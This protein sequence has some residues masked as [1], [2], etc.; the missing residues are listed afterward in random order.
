LIIG[1]FLAIFQQI[2]GINTIM[3][4]A[5]VIFDTLGFSM[6]SS[7]FQTV[8]IGCINFIFT[9]VAMFFVDKLGRKPLL[10]IGSTLMSLSLGILA[11]SVNKGI[12]GYWVLVCILVYIAAFAVSLGPVT[13]VLIS[14]IFPNKYRG[15]GMSISTMFLWASCFAIALLFP[16]VLSSLGI[17]NTFLLF[18]V[19]CIASFVFYWLCIKETKNTKLEN[20]E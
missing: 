17:A 18:M 8:M 6:D 19:I 14:E 11:F 1:I 20:I 9:I 3:Y 7:L 10:L 2:T 12:G 4:Y 16:V 13:W 15:I 5:P